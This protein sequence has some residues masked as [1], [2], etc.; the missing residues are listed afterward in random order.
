MV[1]LI[2]ENRI[3]SKTGLDL[4]KTGQRPGLQALLAA[5]AISD[6]SLNADDIAF[7]LAPRLNAAG[8]M[9]HAARAVNLLIAEDAE[10]AAKT[11]QTLNLLNRKRQDL[12]KGILADI[13]QIINTSPSLLRRQS[14]VLTGPKWH[15]GRS[16]YRFWKA[17]EDMLWRP[18]CRSGR[19]KLAIFKM[20]LKCKSN[21]QRLRKV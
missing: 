4:I 21:A 6:R 5:S 8:R 1:P 18:D 17:S 7:R 10:A 2:G 11:A 20:P 19:K 9:D 14:L 13:Q 12:E 15:A 3:L 16:F